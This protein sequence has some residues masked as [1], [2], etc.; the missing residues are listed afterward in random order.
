MLLWDRERDVLRVVAVA[1]FPPEM[2]GFELAFG[3]GMSSQAILG[4]RTIQVDRYET[5]EHR[6][7]AL[8]HYE[9]GAVLCAPLDRPGHGDRGHQR[10]RPR[11][12]ARV[13]GGWR[14]PARRLRR[15]R[16]DRHRSRPPV[17]ERGPARARPGRDEPR[18]DPV[19]DGPAAT[20]RGRPR[21]CRAGRDRHGRSPS[22]STGVSS[23]RID[24]HRAIAGAAPDGGEAWRGL[25]AADGPES[26]ADHDR[27]PRRTGRRG[28][29]AAVV[30]RRARS[31]PTA[32]SSTS[33]RPVSPSSS[34]RNERRRKWRSACAARRP[35]TC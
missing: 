28:L 11:R 12:P 23:S 5:Y 30:G 16:R 1:N 33:R 31:R 24:L 3:E 10:A 13:P 14:R 9:F 2:L 20:R 21:R 29:P 17:R 4:R 22:T 34:P 35:R 6:A 27:R 19:A 25:L 7:T 18:P 26:T 8:E 32:P 15:P